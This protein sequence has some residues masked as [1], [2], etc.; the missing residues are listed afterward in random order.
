M[1][2]R[3]LTPGVLFLLA[4]A[5]CSD[6]A[7]ILTDARQDGT[8][9]IEYPLLHGNYE[10]HAPIT[11]GGDMTGAV[12]T[13]SLHLAQPSRDTPHFSGS[14]AVRI[15]SMAGE[16]SNLFTGNVAGGVDTSGAVTLQ[17]IDATRNV[18][19]WTGTLDRTT[20]SGTWRITA[21]DQSSMSGNFTATR[22]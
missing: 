22:Q 9:R 8:L 15:V 14:Y 7:A 11:S 16:Q 2:T 21:P 13:G 3:P 20:I 17:F 10:L 5:A 18:F 12:Y 4:L 1:T 6:S 19:R